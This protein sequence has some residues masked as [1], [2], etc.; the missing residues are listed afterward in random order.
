MVI[1]IEKMSNAYAVAVNGV[2]V[3]AACETIAAA[4]RVVDGIITTENEIQ[5]RLNRFINIS[6]IYSL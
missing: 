6:V 4:E 1:S 2:Y 3:S 5:N